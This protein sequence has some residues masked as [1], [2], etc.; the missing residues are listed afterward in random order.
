MVNKAYGES[1]RKLQNDCATFTLV[2][3]D[4]GWDVNVQSCE[5]DTAE[6]TAVKLQGCLLCFDLVIS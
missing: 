1:M 6:F 2:K 5:T 3:C 4:K